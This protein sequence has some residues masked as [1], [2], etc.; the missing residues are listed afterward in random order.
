MFTRVVQCTVK[1]EKRT[2]FSSALREVLP[3]IKQQPGCIDV[4]ER[5]SEAN[6]NEFVCM[7]FW[8]TKEALDHYNDGLV[9]RITHELTPLVDEVSVDNYAVE[10]S[11]AHHIAAGQ[12]A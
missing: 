12:A 5:Y 1:P 3:K 10:T 6:P 8:Q 4:V 2:E 9:Q 7:T 11:T